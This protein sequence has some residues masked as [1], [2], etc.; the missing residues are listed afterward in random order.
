[1]ADA[2]EQRG[3]EQRFELADA[4]ADG[5]LG[6]RQFVGRLGKAAVAGHRFE[7]HQPGDRGDARGVVAVS[8]VV[9]GC[10]PSSEGAFRCRSLPC[11]VGEN[12]IT[13][14]ATGRQGRHMRR[15]G[16]GFVQSVSR[17]RPP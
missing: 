14:S 9:H 12:S 13:L 15:P 7:G 2:D 10:R 17:S 8:V 16:E 5:A 3:A 4:V 1:M 11:P 6:D